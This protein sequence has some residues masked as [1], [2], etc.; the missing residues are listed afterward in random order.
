ML[1]TSK[2]RMVGE[3]VKTEKW[4]MQ[5]MITSYSSSWPPIL[6]WKIDEGETKEYEPRKQQKRKGWYKVGLMYKSHIDTTGLQKLPQ[7]NRLAG[8]LH[9]A[10]DKAYWTVD[11][12][13]VDIKRKDMLYILKN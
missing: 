10:N 7:K 4:D 6:A 1:Y 3:S 11:S 8:T 9:R 5:A 2:G 12:E 13:W